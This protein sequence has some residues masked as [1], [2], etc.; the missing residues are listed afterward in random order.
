MRLVETAA[1]R[2]ASAPREATCELI[3]QQRSAT[4]VAV[5]DEG[6]VARRTVKVREALELALELERDLAAV[7]FDGSWADMLTPRE[8][9][10]ICKLDIGRPKAAARVRLAT[11]VKG[12]LLI[13]VTHVVGGALGH[14]VVASSGSA[15]VWAKW[16]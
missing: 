15:E 2:V 4:C 6:Q 10:P 3:D 8:R 7:V 16:E 14:V 5:R 11:H 12:S 13:A 9:Q 1:R